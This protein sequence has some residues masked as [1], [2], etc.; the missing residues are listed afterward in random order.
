MM[1]PTTM[2]SLRRTSPFGQNFVGT[3]VLCGREGL[4]FKDMSGYC[5]NQR[6]LTQDDALIEAINRPLTGKDG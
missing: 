3:C 5:D 2:H 4:T 1:R 6:G